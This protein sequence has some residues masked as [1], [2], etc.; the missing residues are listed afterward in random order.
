MYLLT[1]ILPFYSSVSFRAL[2]ALKLF[3]V[4]RMLNKKTGVMEIDYQQAPIRTFV[5]CLSAIWQYVRKSRA[6]FERQPDKGLLGKSVTRFFH[7]IW[8]YFFVGGFG[9]LGLTI[10]Y[11]TLCLSI[12]TVSLGLGLTTF[13][14]YPVL[15]LVFHILTALIFDWELMVGDIKRQFSN[16]KFL[17]A[18]LLSTLLRLVF[19]GVIFPVFNLFAALLACPSLS[20][21]IALFATVRKCFRKVQDTLFYHLVL[22]RLARVPSSD[23]F[24]A[25]RT[26]GPG[27]AC[28]HIYQMK[29]ELALAAVEHYIDSQIADAFLE[30]IRGRL[31]EPLEV[32]KNVLIP[33]CEPYSFG[34]SSN[35]DAYQRLS[36][37]ISE[38]YE[39]FLRLYEERTKNIQFYRTNEKVRLTKENLQIVLLEGTELVKLNYEHVI[40][41]YKNDGCEKL[42]KAACVDNYDWTAY[43]G[44]LLER[45]FGV[46]ILTPIEDTDDC[47]DLKVD[48]LNLA[49]YTKMINESKLRDDLDKVFERYSPKSKFVSINIPEKSFGHIFDTT[50][51]PGSKDYTKRYKRFFRIMFCL[52]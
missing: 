22:R 29:P 50:N 17:V 12:S 45:I 9:S 21:L 6:N 37:E 13:L 10:V 2:F 48:H 14:W 30:Y 38:L 8:A 27:M 47:F 46:G 20:V 15:S 18:P 42:F 28:N 4:K 44:V 40:Q 43:T 16:K 31:F 51:P 11:P 1:F 49:K 24:V 39:K 5:S 26:A 7:R 36:N 52:K 33:I 34:F 23:S 32:Y 35:G 19:G 25:R 3:H 41:R